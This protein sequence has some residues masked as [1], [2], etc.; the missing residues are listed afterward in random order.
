MPQP[1]QLHLSRSMGSGCQSRRKYILYILF[2]SGATA[3]AAAKGEGEEEQRN[4]SQA[5]G[6]GRPRVL[7]QTT[8]AQ[9]AGGI[10]G[11]LSTRVHSILLLTPVSPRKFSSFWFFIQ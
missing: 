2:N 1:S 4:T 5:R 6:A 8:V 9:D 3:A 7:N 11:K 10:G